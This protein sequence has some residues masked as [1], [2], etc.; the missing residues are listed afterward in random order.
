MAG[1]EYRG[2]KPGSRHD[3]TTREEGVIRVETG[4]SGFS[5]SAEARATASADECDA[6]QRTDD[7]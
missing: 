5:V 1:S 2:I 7:G 6:I 3:E 4:K